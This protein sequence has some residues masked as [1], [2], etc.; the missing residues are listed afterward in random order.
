MAKT[1]VK[2]A[3][4]VKSAPATKTTAAKTDVAVRK[5]SAGGVVDIKAALAAQVA[6]LGERIQPAGGNTIRLSSG[7]FTLPDGTETP[8]PIDLVV[9]DFVATHDFYTGKYDSKNPSPP[10]CF[11]IGSNPKQMVPSDNS[12]NRQADDC[13]SCSMNEFGSNGDG[14]ACKNGRSL[15]V[16]PPDD[17]EADLWLLNVSPTALKN[18]D[19]FVASAARVFSLPPV[20]VVVTVSLDPNLDYPRL[21]FTDPRPVEDVGAFMARQTEARDMLTVEPDVSGYVA[22]GAATGK[23]ARKTVPIKSARR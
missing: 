8:G 20:G 12:P 18:F 9:V 22:P 7:K 15:A 14:K 11:A 19:G 6:A 17:A 1:P 10:A 23:P 2:P 21:V 3:P 16:L 13:Q 4:A 5:P